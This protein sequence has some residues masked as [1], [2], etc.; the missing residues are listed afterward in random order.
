VWKRWVL[1]SF[2]VTLSLGTGG[3]SLGLVDLGGLEVLA[4]LL[5]VDKEEVLLADVLL[6][7]AAEGE[8]VRRQHHCE[9]LY[10]TSKT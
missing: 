1:T 3:D 5:A 9:T 7:E 8:T 4:H 6:E 2:G 10:V